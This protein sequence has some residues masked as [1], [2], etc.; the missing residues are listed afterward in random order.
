MK[1]ITTID[2]D[3][4]T[5]QPKFELGTH[6][7]T[8]DEKLC[9]ESAYFAITKVTTGKGRTVDLGCAECVSSAAQI[10]K[11]YIALV[12]TAEAA[13]NETKTLR[14]LPPSH[15]WKDTHKTIDAEA[16]RVGCEFP[17]DVTR[18]DDKIT[19][20]EAFIVEHPYADEDQD[21]EDQDEI[22]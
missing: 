6:D 1:R 10:V 19:H 3:I 7:W 22:L 4:E 17:E 9:I 16:E 20:L 12:E 2:A 13:E 18:K 5:L 8:K 21:D 15:N 14:V 11:N